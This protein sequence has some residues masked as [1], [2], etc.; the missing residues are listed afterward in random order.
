MNMT[1][2]PNPSGAVMNADEV[3]RR[4]RVY[5]NKVYM[6]MA[7]ALITTAT[8]AA[9]AADS[10]ETMMW[11]TSGAGSLITILGSLGIIVIMHLMRN[12]L[13]AGALTMLFLT[14]SALTGLFFGPLLVV[15]T[16]QSLGLAFGCTAG[17]FGAMSLYGAMTKRNLSTMGRFM[18]MALIGLIICSVLNIF[19]GS[20]MLDFVICIAGVL[21]FSGL[22]AYDT[23][24]LIE[25]GGI[26]E[27]HQMAKP[28]VFGALSLYLDFINLFLYILRLIGNRD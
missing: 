15:Y 2:Y 9:Y 22:T 21:I 18:F 28:A 16:S 11:V 25:E 1:S 20:S 5:L 26:L 3:N 4:V 23:Q 7:I 8:V 14:Y 17:T 19:V 6:W 27:E 12:K 24:K 13:T 10:T